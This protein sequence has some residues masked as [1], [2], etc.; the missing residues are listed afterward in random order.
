ML[1]SLCRHFVLPNSF[2]RTNKDIKE[3]FFRSHNLTNFELVELCKRVSDLN[4]MDIRAEIGKQDFLKT[5]ILNIIQKLPGMDSG[6]IIMVFKELL[7][8]PEFRDFRNTYTLWPILC[9]ILSQR[10]ETL[11]LE[12]TVDSIHSVCFLRIATTMLEELVSNLKR[13]LQEFDAKDF[14]T[15]PLNKF[16]SLLWALNLRRVES[17]SVYQQVYL[18]FI[19]HKDFEYI[20]Y[21]QISMICNFFIQN[22][23]IAKNK[24][25]VKPLVSKLIESIEHNK[26]RS[27]HE[28][29]DIVY[30][31][32]QDE[33]LPQNIHTLISDSITSRFG[34]IMSSGTLLRIMNSELKFS[35]ELKILLADKLIEYLPGFTLLDLVNVFLSKVVVNNSELKEKI[36][37]NIQKKSK[38]M[39]KMQFSKIEKM[40]NGINLASNSTAKELY[41]ILEYELF[42]MFETSIASDS[43]LI[44]SMKWSIKAETKSS[45]Y[46]IFMGKLLVKGRLPYYHTRDIMSLIVIV[47]NYPLLQTEKIYEFIDSKIFDYCH[48]FEYIETAVVYYVLSRKNRLWFETQ[49][50]VSKRLQ[51]KDSNSVEV[52][53]F[54]LTLA[55]AVMNTNVELC[56]RSLPIIR[57]LM[58]FRNFE[59]NY[60]R[61]GELMKKII[62][63]FNISQLTLIRCL[64]TLAFLDIKDV[65]ILN[66]DVYSKI[67]T[68]EPTNE[69]ASKHLS[70]DDK[71]VD[72]F[73]IC[74]LI[75]ALA[76]LGKDY[77]ECLSYIQK[78]S[79]VVKPYVDQYEFFDNIIEDEISE[80]ALGLGLTVSKNEIVYGNAIPLKVEGKIVFV[81]K[82]EHYR[83]QSDGYVKAKGMNFISGFYFMRKKM[84]LALN[85]PFVEIEKGVWDEMS[86]EEKK[87][88]II[89]H[90]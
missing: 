25:T 47:C 64:W 56:R 83:F 1:R 75:Q 31:M 37:E 59:Y 36:L 53:N 30:F 55:S 81:Y 44:R 21:E 87:N 85:I 24:E 80:I 27:F 18:G 10:S 89:N 34:E 13:R 62:S 63:D 40:I 17:E 19:Q 66:S 67:M 65:R 32:T 14:S 49:E 76:V 52:E 8:N 42:S 69:M 60:L 4:I 12:Q 28:L 45:L 68:F 48:L 41:L 79:E 43:L 6:E 57:V 3:L 23:L 9:K 2:G 71:S 73:H 82:N 58:A 86:Q 16:T 5:F 26:I 61:M 51:E 38:D 90:F 50:L 11:T 29:T 72:G 78:L 74:I 46:K 39:Y 35:D 54:S 88:L 70:F 84:M 20:S 33:S 77:P 22:K 15:L 7:K